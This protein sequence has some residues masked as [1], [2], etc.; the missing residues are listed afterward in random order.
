MPGVALQGPLV[1]PPQVQERRLLG[2]AGGAG[3]ADQPAAPG[4]TSACQ[5]I[6]RA[7]CQLVGESLQIYKDL[8]LYLLNYRNYVAGLQIMAGP[9]IIVSRVDPRP[10][11]ATDFSTA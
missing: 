7:L 1:L 11:S 9:N 2:G 10:L 4:Q 3:G 5:G 8:V 6:G